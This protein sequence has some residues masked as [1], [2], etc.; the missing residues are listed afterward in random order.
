MVNFLFSFLLSFL[1]VIAGLALRGAMFGNGSLLAIDAWG[2]YY[3]MLCAMKEAVKS[4]ELFWSY[5]GLLGFNLWAQNAYYTNSILWLP[6]YLLP[7]RFM[8]AGINIFAAIRIGLAGLTC[9]IYLYGCTTVKKPRGVDMKLSVFSAAYALSAYTLAFIN[10][11]MWMDAVICLP[12][13]IKGIDNI[14]SK[15]GGILYIAALSYTIISNFYIG[16]MV[17]LFSVVYFAG[18]VIGD[19]MSLGQLWEKVWRFLLYSLIA[20]AISAVYTVPAYYAIRNTAASGAGFG[21]KIEFYHPVSEVLAGFLPFQKISLVYEVPN[22]YCGAVC[23]LLC[24]LSFFIQKNIRKRICIISGCIL[25][26]LSLN[27]NILD[28]VWHGFHYPNQL[29]G[30][31]SFCL[32]F[33]IV[34]QAYVCC[35]GFEK[36]HSRFSWC[37]VIVL[38]LFAEVTANAVYTF[39]S[40]IRM[41][42]GNE[43]YQTM[44]KYEKV[45]GDIKAEDGSAFYRT[46]LETPWNFNPGQLCGYNGISY[47]SSTMSK[48]A[49]DFFVNMGMS[50][51]AKNLSTRYDK[52]CAADAFLG[53]KYRIN[54][55]KDGA[56]YTKNE[57]ALPIGYSIKAE[58]CEEFVKLLNDKSADYGTVKS[59]IDENVLGKMYD[60]SVG[61]GWHGL[62]G[63]NEYISGNIMTGSGILVISL[64]YNEGWSIYIDGV[65]RRTES[66]AGYMIMTNIENGIHHIE[67]KH[68]TK[69]LGVGAVISI[70][71]IAGVGVYYRKRN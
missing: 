32:I 51:Y 24:I 50:V 70:L 43:Y 41:V 66:L 13:V 12:L 7:D 44:E 17:C 3:P 4:G 55:G 47:Y 21:G 61:N 42:D 16:Y 6:L 18:C 54:N 35:G 27:C 15:K 5:K 69:G 62:A 53:V 2:Q 37:R 28:Y 26:Y 40:Q 64:P 48:T 20:G 38:V 57:A 58:S 8:I 36:L 49:Y 46:E 10:Q 65:K 31:W 22:I 34:K 14:R 25:F 30:R 59:F 19:R 33:L 56:G 67:M 71:A 23:I 11:F 52:S 9:S 45:A 29:P 68:R 60:I 39:Y 63:K 1:V